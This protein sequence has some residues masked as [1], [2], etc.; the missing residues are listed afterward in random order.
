M[1][2]R[3]SLS[4]KSSKLTKISHYSNYQ[5]QLYNEIKMFKEEYD[6]GYRRISYLI[7]EKGYRGVR[8]NQVLRNNDIHSI[9]KKGKIRENRIKRDFDTIIDD[10]VVYENKLPIIFNRS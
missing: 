5:Q 2:V 10:V 8:N 6:L 7:Y 3:I 9:Y 1:I 4:T